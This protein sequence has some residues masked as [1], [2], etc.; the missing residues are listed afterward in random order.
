MVLWVVWCGGRERNSGSRCCDCCIAAVA[1]RSVCC[2]HPSPPPRGRGQNGSS[3][4]CGCRIAVVAARCVCCPH[5][6]PPPRG[7]GQNGGSR[8]CGCRIV[9]VAVRLVFCLH[10]GPSPRG[11]ERN[12][13]SRCCGC[14]IEQGWNTNSATTRRFASDTPPPPWGRAGVGAADKSRSVRLIWFCVLPVCSE[15]QL[16]RH[17][18]VARL[19][20][21]RSG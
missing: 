19:R 9:V 7:R 20:D 5:P 12:G 11:R 15:W 18:F 6:S 2:P 3:R 8:C 4:C 16:V 17:G 13:G 10:S 21:S 14:C 1:A